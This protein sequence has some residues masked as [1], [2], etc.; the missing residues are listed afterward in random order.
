MWEALGAALALLSLTTNFFCI[1][2]YE[3][4][5]NILYYEKKFQACF[6]VDLRHLIFRDDDAEQ[7]L[8]QYYFML[9]LTNFVHY[10]N[11]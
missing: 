11:L 7:L 6:C 5:S 8:T 4:F 9:F 3:K 1:S 10:S 2:V